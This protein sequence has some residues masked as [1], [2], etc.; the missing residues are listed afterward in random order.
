MRAWTR[1]ALIIC[2]VSNHFAPTGHIDEKTGDAGYLFAIEKFMAADTQK[3]KWRGKQISLQTRSSQQKDVDPD[4]YIS[5]LVLYTYCIQNYKLILYTSSPA[6]YRTYKLRR[7]RKE[8]IER[9]RF[10]YT[11]QEKQIVYSE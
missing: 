11:K 5:K 2:F 9:C 1:V 6:I 7:S 10:R 4:V 3:R 8:E